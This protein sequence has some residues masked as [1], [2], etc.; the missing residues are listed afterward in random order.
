MMQLIHDV[1]PGAQLMFQTL[2]GSQATFATSV[3]AFV[4]AGCHVIVDTAV[5]SIYAPAFQDGINAQAV[6]AAVK[7]GVAFFSAAGDDASKSYSAPFK[8]S[9]VFYDD[10]GTLHEWQPNVIEFK[11]QLSGFT[12]INLKWD[13]P[14]AS[15][16]GSPGSASNLNFYLLDDSGFLVAG[17]VENSIGGDANKDLYISGLSNATYILA[18]ALKEG[19]PPGLMKIIM[20]T[21]TNTNP[22]A[23]ISPNLDSTS[24]IIGHANAALGATIGGSVALLWNN[25]SSLLPNATRYSGRGGTPI[26][27]SKNGTRLPK[28]EIRQKPLV[29]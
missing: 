19:P 18:V 26:L 2:Y 13:E 5:T 27:F 16:P 29:I 6:D 25:P 21:T 1:A 8:P 23:S 15:I 11:V 17:T 28:P 12:D 4:T 7:S 10:V 9:N 3:A 20:R 14:S 24:T 22:F